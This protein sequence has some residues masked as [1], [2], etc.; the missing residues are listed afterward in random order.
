VAIDAEEDWL[1][2]MPDI[3]KTTTA[4]IAMTAA[5][6]IRYSRLACARIINELSGGYIKSL[7]MLFTIRAII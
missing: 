1:E 2:R 7:G 6:M 5:T 4:A 3:V